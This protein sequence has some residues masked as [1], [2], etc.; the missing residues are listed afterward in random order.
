MKLL[1]HCAVRKAVLAVVVL[2]LCVFV[3]PAQAD[4]AS[5]SDLEYMVDN[6]EVIITDCNQEATGTLTI[7]ATIGGK[8]VVK[9]DD[10]AFDYCLNLTKIV[11][12]DSVKTI[13]NSSFAYC[14]MLQNITLG[15]NL[16]M[17]DSRAFLSC[18]SLTQI[19][20][21][22]SLT[23]IS[24]YAF[25]DCTA[26]K[27]ITIPEGVMI[28]SAGAFQG[29]SAMT[30]ISIPNSIS[31]IGDAAFSGCTSL[32]VT[33]Y[34][35][36]N[37]IGNSKNPYV[38][39]VGPRNDLITTYAIHKDAK[40]I[41]SGAFAFCGQLTSVTIPK[42]VRC[43]SDYAF[44]YCGGLKSITIPN[45]VEYIGFETFRGCTGLT[46]LTIPDSVTFIDGKAFQGCTKLK[47]VTLSKNLDSLCQEAFKDCIALTSIVIP[48]RVLYI[49]MDLFCGCSSLKSVT[50]GNGIDKIPEGAFSYCSAL[51]SVTIPSG[52][53]E[54]GNIA[55]IGCSALTDIY[56]PE[57]V[58]KIGGSAFQE[59]TA[60]KTAIITGAVSSL[61]WE[62]FDDCSALT[63]IVLPASLEKISYGVFSNCNS[64]SKVYFAGTY[65]QW[66]EIYV[67]DNNSPLQ[68]ASKCTGYTP[69]RFMAQPTNQYKAVGKT[70]SFKV[71]ATDN[72][73]TYQ[74]QYRTSSTG[75]WTNVSATNGKTANYTLS[76]QARHNGY[77]YRCVV[78]DRYGLSYYSQ[79]VKLSVFSVT[80]QPV[81]KVVKSGATAK[82][83]VSATGKG[84]TYQWQYR[85]SST[86]SWTNVTAANGKT[87][88]YSLSTQTRHNGYQY[89]C[90]IKDSAGNT[91]YT[92]V[93]TLNVLG[94]KTQPA[95]KVVKSGVTAKFT[96]SAT[97]KGLTY[98]WQ[99]RKSSSGSWTN[100]STANGKSA[101]YSLTTQVR[102]NGY[103]Y[104]CRVK[105]SAGNTVYTNV[106][107]LNVLGIKT[108][109][110][111]KVVKSGAT[112][113]FTVFATGKGLTYQWQ[114]RTSSNG[115]WT[116]VSAANGKTANYSL[117]TQTRHNG[118]QY[119][120]RIKDSAGNTVYTNVVTLNVLGIQTQPVNR[121][122]KS[123][124]TAKFTVSAT[125]KG[126]T[127]QWQYRTSS[128]GTWTNVSTAN[129]KTANYSL[130]S[131]TRHNAYQYRCRIKDA[132]GNIVYT[133]VVKLT[134]K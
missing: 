108:Q 33:V 62:A 42:G 73:L 19:S 113:K 127:Y 134:V 27:S 83:T 2:L 110:V 99:Y 93:V 26:L 116:N 15:K 87:A 85:T 131:Q 17:I 72:S 89:R 24:Y 66:N 56:I 98:Q 119:R 51:E 81:S 103:Q 30:S 126:L 37:Y 47:S 114:Y 132:A 67:M 106:V 112:A 16:E 74:W 121:V 95:S 100:V 36:G 38:V 124:A 44:C 41:Y 28:I 97:G 107:T 71:T 23:T 18:S 22:S 133:S 59:C 57:S 78:T 104:R 20:L 77:A 65:Q 91:V 76:V 7:P 117:S 25:Q 122:V 129:G 90:R 105:D 63:A 86:G 21:P 82:F 52:V 84:L 1:F 35:N 34:D 29:C 120:C 10:Y 12:P 39:F 69:V 8:P 109:P 64:L 70:A 123:G 61:E 130:I 11:L 49:G 6:G 115:S 102:H 31:Y 68:S 46:K 50:L 58:T 43:I 45:S 40:I 96:V 111:S 4:A 92:N 80:T 14:T 118:Y 60:L 101:N 125:G 9:I 79:V 5:V 55:F 75:N 128:T 88:N 32:P 3:I 13:G 48:D 53:T 54:I 94:I